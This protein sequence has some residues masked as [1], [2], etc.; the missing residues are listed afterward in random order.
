MSSAVQRTQQTEITFLAV[1]VSARR[2]ARRVRKSDWYLIDDTLPLLDPLGSDSRPGRPPSRHHAIISVW[3]DIDEFRPRPGEIVLVR[4]A[5]VNRNY[6]EDTETHRLRKLDKGMAAEWG[7]LNLYP[8][9][10]PGWWATEEML[11]GMEVEGFRELREWRDG[12]LK[13]EEQEE[14]AWEEQQIL[15]REREI[16]EK[17]EA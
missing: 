14:R 17:E 16:T 9:V 13:R 11:E 15:R 5:K 4:G 3:R 8:N 6:V 1:V 2:D 7:L 12:V 10:R